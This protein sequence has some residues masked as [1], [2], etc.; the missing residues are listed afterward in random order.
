MADLPEV[1]QKLSVDR[2]V[3]TFQR[4]F[5]NTFSLCHS[6]TT[7]VLLK[8]FGGTFL[9]GSGLKLLN[10]ILLYMTPLVFRKIIQSIE[11]EEEEWKGYLWVVLL[12]V[13]AT[14]QVT[15]WNTPGPIFRC[16]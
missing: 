5:R 16:C 2:I 7:T 3:E 4:H 9:Q 6:K 12:L 15:D 1:N 13:T 14:L 10:D 8:S 11:N